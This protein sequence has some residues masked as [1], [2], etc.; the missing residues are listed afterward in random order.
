MHEAED[1]TKA[2]EAKRELEK[3][4]E[5]RLWSATIMSVCSLGAGAGLINHEIRNDG[6][7]DGLTILTGLGAIAGAGA[8]MTEVR[9]YQSL[10]RK[11]IL[12]DQKIQEFRESLNQE[13]EDLINRSSDEEIGRNG[14]KPEDWIEF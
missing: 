3:S 2:R 11:I 1:Y 10:N 14:D 9:K 4:R 8:M 13:I 7:I 5:V 12:N 6:K